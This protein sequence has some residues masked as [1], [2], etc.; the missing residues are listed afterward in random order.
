MLNTN[1]LSRS[2]LELD[3]MPEIDLFA[4]RLN[5]QFIR[6]VAFRA[7]PGPSAID[8]FTMN[9]SDLN[10]SAFPPFSVIPAVLKKIKGGRGHGDMH[11]TVL[12]HTSM[13]SSGVRIGNLKNHSPETQQN[14]PSPAQP[15]KKDTPTVQTTRAHGL[16][17][18]RETLNTRNIS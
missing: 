12:A 3:F 16:P 18:T 15:A 8:A 2:L 4:S 10:F 13:V 7:D 11:I 5:A 6:Y 9:W 17:L 14:A 1:V